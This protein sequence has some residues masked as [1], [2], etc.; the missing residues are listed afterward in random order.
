MLAL[1]MLKSL[2]LSI[3]SSSPSDGLRVGRVLLRLRSGI[4]G[5]LRPEPLRTKPSLVR[6]RCRPIVGDRG[7]ATLDVLLSVDVFAVLADVEVDVFVELAVLPSML[8]F[9]FKLLKCPGG[10]GSGP[11][12]RTGRDDGPLLLWG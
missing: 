9:L 11:K 5:S 4:C 1:S 8:T 2:P 10:G 12:G 3:S 6:P 7:E